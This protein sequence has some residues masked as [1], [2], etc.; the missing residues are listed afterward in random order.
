M[1]TRSAKQM[2]TQSFDRQAHS[3]RNVDDDLSDV[4]SERSTFTQ[5]R[6]TVSRNVPW[7]FLFFIIVSAFSLR[8]EIEITGTYLV[9][10]VENM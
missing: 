4:R 7:A 6:E 9:G 5:V 10:L 8:E 3:V 2:L 1:P